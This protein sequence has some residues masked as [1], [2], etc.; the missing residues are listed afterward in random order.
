M[1]KAL[2]FIL[3]AA[4]LVPTA[5]CAKSG[6]VAG[7]IYSTDIR[8]C[9][10]GVWVNSYNI[11]GKTAVIVEDITSQYAYCDALRTL[12]IDDFAPDKLVASASSSGKRP[13]TVIGNIYETDIKT[14]F[15]GKEL[16]S[17]SLN[18]RMAVVVEE[19]GDDNT[20]SEIG[21]KYVWNSEKRT[22]ELQS[23][24]RYPYSMR[25]LMEE[26]HYNINLTYSYGVLEAQ[27]VKAPLDGGYILCEKEIPANSIVPVT[28]N[29]ETIGYR[30]SFAKNK[31]EQD[32]NGEF[33]A[34]EVQTPVDFFYTDKVSDMIFES[35]SVQITAEDWLNYFKLHTQSTVYD[36]F[37]TDDYIFL[38]MHS[39]YVMKGSDR[40]IKLS[41]ADGTK[42][43]YQSS[44]SDE[45]Y[46]RFENVSIDRE[47]EEVYVTCGSEYVIDLKTDTV[48]RYVKIKTDIGE[49]R[50]DG[51]LSEYN[52]K[53][54]KDSAVKYRLSSGDAEITIVGFMANEYYYSPMLP[55]CETLDFLN[56]GYSFEND[57][58]T[59]DLSDAKASV[60]VTA[61]EEKADFANVGDVS[62]LYLDK[63]LVNGEEKDI[64][65]SYS[66]GHFENT[67][68]GKKQAK[69]YVAGGK[70]YVTCEFILELVRGE[71]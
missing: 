55:L 10:N 32:E 4:M 42:I 49:G 26:N 36:R 3:A 43:E 50:T 27:P 46:I 12:E 29:G 33:Y 22:L 8:T 63:V 52:A 68:Y 14:Y 35:G 37:E 20:F 17:Y 69:P 39:S 13:G 60:D 48:S 15:R 16:T 62:Y 31:F 7:K 71:K 11:G 18:G 44:V 65:Y 25:T 64:T 5:V 40:L 61:T 2:S 47:K 51:E 67:Y 23:M 6:D 70:V 66:S 41:K 59:I 24:Y 56:I 1:K 30:C 19:L 53:C 28:Y 9:I 38:Y 45:S 54:A 21:G 34:R 58:L 57:I